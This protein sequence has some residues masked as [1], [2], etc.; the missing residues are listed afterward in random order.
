MS[1]HSATFARAVPVIGVI[2]SQFTSPLPAV[3]AQMIPHSTFEK[4][5]WAAQWFRSIGCDAIHISPIHP[6]S[7][8][9]VEGKRG[10]VYAAQDHMRVAPYLYDRFLDPHRW[11]DGD[12]VDK[13]QDPEE[14]WRA[15]AGLA[16]ENDSCIR[17]MIHRFFQTAREK[18][19]P[20]LETA[21]AR[22]L[23]LNSGTCRPP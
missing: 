8:I 5:G 9:N 19:F 12:Y 6:P 4:I 10:S 21:R 17:N 1:P 22:H 18:E 11:L 16:D 15:L 14:G 20:A 13:Y 2:P 7:Q 23:R 3:M